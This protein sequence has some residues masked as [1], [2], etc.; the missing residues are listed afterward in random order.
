MS[1]VAVEAKQ[2]CAAKDSWQAGIPTCWKIFS[3][4]NKTFFM[5]LPW[6][7]GEVAIFF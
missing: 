2:A 5:Q 1:L 3:L 6:V 7:V 4:E